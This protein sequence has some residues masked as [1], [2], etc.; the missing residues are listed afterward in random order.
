MKVGR[1]WSGYFKALTIGIGL[2]G[3]SLDNAFAAD[4]KSWP[5][6]V[7]ALATACDDQ[8]NCEKR[9]ARVPDVILKHSQS[10]RDCTAYM[11]LVAGG[12]RVDADG[13]VTHVVVTCAVSRHAPKGYTLP[14][15]QDDR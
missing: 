10:I 15:S 4:L 5:M 2:A 7:W 13:N 3:A 8:L 6:P 9:A 12:T 1:A 14:T 11:T